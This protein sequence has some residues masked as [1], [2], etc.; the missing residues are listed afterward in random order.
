[1]AKNVLMTKRQ[2]KKEQIVMWMTNAI[3]PGDPILKAMRAMRNPMNSWDK[4]DTTI[5]KEDGES[6]F[7]QIGPNDISLAMK[8]GAAGPS[9]SKHLR[10]IMVYTDIS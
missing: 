2:M 9:H 6:A 7:V 4:G 8:L 1:M 5:V 3:V 10:F